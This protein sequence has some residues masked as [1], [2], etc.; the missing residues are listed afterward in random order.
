MLLMVEV[1]HL[2]LLGFRCERGIHRREAVLLV[3]IPFLAETLADGI[4]RIV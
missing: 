3:R 4:Q 2:R 1:P